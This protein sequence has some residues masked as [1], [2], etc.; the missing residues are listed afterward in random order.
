M[1]TSVSPKH[2]SISE[3]LTIRGRNF[4]RGRY[5][6]TVV[7]KRDEAKAVFVK[8]EVGTKKMIRV[9][10][11]EKLA[12]QLL[13]MDGTP[14]AT[15]FRLRVLS[16]KLSKKFTRGALV[17]LVGPKKPPVVEAPTEGKPDGDCDLDKVKNKDD[18]DDDND[19][20]LDATEAAIKTDPCVAT[21]T[22][23]ASPTATSS[24]RSI[25]LND[26]EYQEPQNDPARAGQEAVPERALRRLGRGLRR[27]LAHPRPGVLP[28][29][30]PTAT[31]AA[32]LNDLVYSDGNQYS[33]YG[34]DGDG[35]RPA[36]D[37]RRPERQVRE[38]LSGRRQRV[39]HR[40]DPRHVLRQC[41]NGPRAAGR[42][43]TRPGRLDIDVSG[44]VISAT[45]S[46]ATPSCATSTSTSDGKLSDNERDEDADGLT[47][48]DE[49]TGRMT[50]GYWSGCYSEGEAVP[51]P[52]RR[53]EPGGSG[54]GRRRRARRRGR[55]GPRRRP[56]H[57]GAQP[58]RGQRSPAPVVAGA[59]SSA[60]DDAPS[61][62]AR[63]RA[64]STRSTRAS[65][66]RSSDLPA[67]PAAGQ[68]FFP[69]QTPTSPFYQVLN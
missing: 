58:Q 37:R 4:V 30:A 18:R 61:A 57:H 59:T 5:K 47:N 33:A 23:T 51:D 29:D 26:D 69:Y 50:P 53:H 65:R 48:Y 60:D 54:R 24:S 16:K 3:Q 9:T 27:R 21:P 34:R 39:P 1:I 38:L 7:F 17:P 63:T 40:L 41:A 6:N 45:T 36:A 22:A 66:T 49:A 12:D 2:T 55:P 10:V 28:L 8:A 52:L 35:R 13:V 11:S 67:A 15:P 46:T 43:R 42:G 19:L 32:G 20:L 64:T 14:I 62:R 44:T 31:R 56:E 68:P 25:D